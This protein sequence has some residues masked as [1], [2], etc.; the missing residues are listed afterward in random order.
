ME[1][2]HHRGKRSELVSRYFSLSDEAIAALWDIER[3]GYS[4]DYSNGK[5]TDSKRLIAELQSA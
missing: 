5:L 3:Y 4:A 1:S 2:A